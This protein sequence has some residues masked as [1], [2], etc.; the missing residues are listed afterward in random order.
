MIYFFLQV[1]LSIKGIYY[2]AEV[3]GQTITWIIPYQFAHDV[4]IK[5]LIFPPYLTEAPHMKKLE[6]DLK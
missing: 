4:S 5:K 1:F 3:L 6:A 2:Q